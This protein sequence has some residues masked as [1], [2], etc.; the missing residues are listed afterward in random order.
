LLWRCKFYN[1]CPY[2]LKYAIHLYMYSDPIEKNMNL[3]NLPHLN[4][5]GN[6]FKTQFSFWWF[7]LIIFIPINIKYKTTII[8]DI[9][10]HGL[11]KPFIRGWIEAQHSD[12]ES[13][14][15]GLDC[16]FTIQQITFFSIEIYFLQNYTIF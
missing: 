10:N 12:I 6:P 15:V 11:L 5:H 2:P 3:I 1:S 13:T 7:R 4:V 16:V 9:A 14:Y 8:V